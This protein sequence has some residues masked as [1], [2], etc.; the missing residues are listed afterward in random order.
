MTF[1][2]KI[3]PLNTLYITSNHTKIFVTGLTFDGSGVVNM[4]QNA[5][6]VF[7]PDPVSV[8]TPNTLFLM[9]SAMFA[10]LVIRKRKQ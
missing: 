9:L 6:T 2:S 8:P 4:N 3:K 5:V 10:T 1:C 7:V